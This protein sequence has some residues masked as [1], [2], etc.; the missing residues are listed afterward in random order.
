M[1]KL[2]CDKITLNNLDTNLQSVFDMYIL[3]T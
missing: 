1:Y 3:L 2:H